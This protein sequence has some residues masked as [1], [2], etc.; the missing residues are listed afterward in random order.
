MFEK[1]KNNEE[2]HDNPA[3]QEGLAKHDERKF[4]MTPAELDRHA[5][6][7][8]RQVILGEKENSGKKGTPLM[9]DEDRARMAAAIKRE[10]KEREERGK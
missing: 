9:T 3:K 5:A 1:L 10:Q 4:S 8:N 7:L 2:K 6:M